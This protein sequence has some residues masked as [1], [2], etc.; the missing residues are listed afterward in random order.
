MM[1]DVP[2]QAIC[3]GGASEASASAAGCALKCGW[4][5]ERA[6]RAVARAAVAA[7]AA[8]AARG[9]RAPARPAAGASFGIMS[10]RCMKKTED[11]QVREMIRIF[12]VNTRRKQGEQDAQEAATKPHGNTLGWDTHE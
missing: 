3:G 7:A 9:G 4:A 6:V 11:V 1:V 8:T 10:R 5:A 2:P 12:T